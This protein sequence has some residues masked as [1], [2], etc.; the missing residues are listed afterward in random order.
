MYKAATVLKEQFCA[1][2]STA[3]STTP[4]K[5]KG[6]PNPPAL[7]SK[8][9]APFDAEAFAAKLSFT[10]EVEALGLDEDQAKLLGVGVY[11][12]RLYSALRYPSGAV[13]GFQYVEG[14]T[15][16]LPK[17]L[18]PDAAPNVVTFKKRA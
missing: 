12:N 11:R 10:D 8:R 14:G 1:E 15:I 16:V 4:Q 18:L 6:E 13:A 5:V 2:R 7:P 3:P 17:T 9:E